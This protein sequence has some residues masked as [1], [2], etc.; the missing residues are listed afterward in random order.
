MVK[1]IFLFTIFF[2][3][4]IFFFNQKGWVKI[5][6]EGKKKAI[7]LV[8]DGKNVIEKFLKIVGDNLE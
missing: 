8:L 4:A 7:I 6:P 1:N 3:I 2:L 5:T